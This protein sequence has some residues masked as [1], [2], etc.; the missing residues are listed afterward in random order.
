MQTFSVFFQLGIEHILDFTAYDHLLFMALLALGCGINNWRPLLFLVTAFTIGHSITLALAVID[1]VAFNPEVIELLIPITI[2]LAALIK[3]IS[4]FSKQL[5]RPTYLLIL[6]FGLIH[7]FGFSNYLK[8]L[9]GENMNVVW[10]LFA[11]NLG[12]EVAQILIV[13]VILGVQ[14]L[15]FLLIKQKQFQL[16]WNYVLAGLVLILSLQLIY[17]GITNVI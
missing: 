17:N 1:L 4:R 11:F 2:A 7:G 14:T 12:I 16:I 6:V 5:T 9:L 13:S 8:M 15:L 3:M 10:P